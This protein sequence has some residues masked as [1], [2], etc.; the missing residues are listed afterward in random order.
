MIGEASSDAPTSLTNGR[1]GKADASAWLAVAA[2]TLGA[3]MA[4]LDISIVNSSLPTIQGEIGASATEGTW[5]ATSYLVAE[6]IIIPL[7]GWLERL[8]GLRNFLLG[9]AIL[10]TGFSV[11]CGFSNSARTAS[12]F[13]AALLSIAHQIRSGS[14]GSSPSSLCAKSATTIGNASRAG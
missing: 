11:V 2:G 3:L 6:I 5:V 8:L 7:T 4:T 1:I 12:R 13:E 9:A 10:F 14:C